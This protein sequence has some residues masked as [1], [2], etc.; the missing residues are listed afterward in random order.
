[1]SPQRDTH[2]LPKCAIHRDASRIK[3][4]RHLAGW[5]A[6]SQ[7]DH[8]KWPAPRSSRR[9]LSPPPTLSPAFVLQRTP[10]L[11]LL[12]FDRVRAGHEKRHRG[13]LHL[14][15][16]TSEECTIRSAV[17]SCGSVCRLLPA[18]KRYFERTFLRI[19]DKRPP[20]HAMP[21][22]L[23]GLDRAQKFIRLPK[24]GRRILRLLREP[25]FCRCRHARRLVAARGSGCLGRTGL[26]G[27][28]RICFPWGLDC[29]FQQI[30]MR[31][32]VLRRRR[33][34]RCLLK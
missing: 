9:R 8:A 26:S 17:V 29:E 15:T 21:A 30:G 6:E 5:G 31:V 14:R 25:R 23:T 28:A 34:C 11:H 10:L 24:A 4:K 13:R 22:E 2:Q 32:L 7:I 1:M 20:E 33:G 19:V 18:H 12:L 3:P 27:Y 16:H